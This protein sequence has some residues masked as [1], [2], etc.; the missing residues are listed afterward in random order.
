LKD[1]VQYCYESKYNLKQLEEFCMYKQANRGIVQQPNYVFNYM[2]NFLRKLSKRI[3]FANSNSEDQSQKYTGFNPTI[4][5]TTND[6]ILAYDFMEKAFIEQKKL[7]EQ[8]GLGHNIDTINAYSFISHLKHSNPNSWDLDFHKIV[9]DAKVD[10][11]EKEARNVPLSQNQQ[12][13]SNILSDLH[14]NRY[15]SQ[16]STREIL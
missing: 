12:Y 14:M 8:R 1:V 15:T 16:L 3:M 7:I 5:P 10:Y 4:L 9:C 13:F 6:E 11:L 2:I